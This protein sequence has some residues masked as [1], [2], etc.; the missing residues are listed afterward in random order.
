MRTSVFDAAFDIGLA[1]PRLAA[2]LEEEPQPQ[3][4]KAHRPAV[5]PS[6][7][8]AVLASPTEPLDVI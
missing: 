2:W 6:L 4:E 5:S 8:D 1:D 7:F 3:E